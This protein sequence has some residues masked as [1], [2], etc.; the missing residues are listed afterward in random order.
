MHGRTS[1]WVVGAGLLVS[2][3][4]AS[5]TINDAAF[6]EMLFVGNVGVTTALAWAPDG[7]QRLFLAS[8][9]G[10]VRIIERGSL[11][12]A[13]FATVSPLATEVE[14]GLLGIAFDP[15][16]LGNGFVYL[17]A[18]VS[19]GEQQILRYTATGNVGIDKTVI[20]ATLPTRGT[21]H[22]GGALA[23]GPDGKLYWAV[24][25]NGAFFGTG[26]D[27]TLLNAKVGRANRDGSVPGDNPFVDGAGPNNDYIWASGFRNP[28]KMTFEP[29]T[30]A[31]WLSVV[32]T[33]WEQIFTVTKGNNGGYSTYESNQPA[34]YTLPAISY[35]TNTVESHPISSSG[36]V[37]LGGVVT[38][39]TAEPHRF[40]PGAKVSVAGV[41]N[42][43]FNGSFFLT[44]VL[45]P[46]QFNFHQAGPDAV[47]G[48]GTASS[49][50]LGGC[51][52]GGTFWDSTAVPAAYRGNFFFGD[53]VSGKI[54]RATLDDA[55]QVASV[56]EWGSGTKGIV[57]LAIGPDGNLY[58][59]P[60]TGVVN[61]VSY[62]A[63]AQALAVTPQNLRMAEG[64]SAVVHVRLAMA[65]SST[66]TVYVTKLGDADITLIDSSTLK[67]TVDNWWVPQQVELRS[68]SDVD[69]IEDVGRVHLK[70]AGL[71]E[72]DVNV[73][74]TEAEVSSFV[75][76]TDTL[77]IGEGEERE[78]TVALSQPPAATLTVTTA[79]ASGDDDVKVVGG[80]Q[81]TFTPLNWATPQ[82]VTVSASID[83]DG[84]A[85]SATLVVSANGPASREIRIIVDDPD[86][87]AP[88]IVSEPPTT[89][90]IGSVYAYD[91]EAEGLPAPSFVLDEAPSGMTVNAEN[92]FIV[93]IPDEA[94]AQSVVVRAVNG[95]TPEATQRFEIEVEEGQTEPT[96]GAP[97]ASNGG[98]QS[99]MA[100]S[101]AGQLGAGGSSGQDGDD[102]SSLPGSAR[103]A[104]DGC[105]CR[106]AAAK[107]NR[108]GA[109]FLSAITV[110]AALH[111]RRRRSR[112]RRP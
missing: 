97:G 94:G 64:G 73:R 52:T 90:H 76:S 46:T 81:L 13:P 4:T 86:G 8:K 87:L 20:V 59:A 89:G 2:A 108:R 30:G 70:C 37:R 74:V 68:A 107:S 42:P 10:Q 110:L 103:S 54:M 25:D 99:G 1:S 57:D 83:P 14:S 88:T 53:F 44:Q 24:G 62:G 79:H 6:S 78:L 101:H 16:F 51:V 69:S 15:D 95:V 12:A 17:F 72:E 48:S 22:N 36:T 26:A 33:Y 45:S 3:Q 21:N 7:S 38:I 77:S 9:A 93:W 91:V 32:G 34:G 41:S 100:P 58:Y 43:S 92:G 55:N 40:R 104:D 112:S 29:G 65:P 39:H 75:M 111:V 84:A 96:G 71:P 27:L 31:L 105:G 106:V 5:A 18:T 102:T 28:F 60:T 80:A 35:A 56:D 23:F 98:Q 67:F 49:Q 66:Q 109:G 63:T 50:S 82:N 19:E 61:R 11:L 85:D 47:S